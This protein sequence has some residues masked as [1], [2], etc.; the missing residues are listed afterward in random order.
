METNEKWLPSSY[1]G[2]SKHLWDISPNKEEENENI[3]KDEKQDNGECNQVYHG[4]INQRLRI[5][6]NISEY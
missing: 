5:D 4:K 3:M 6:M 2:Q 1:N